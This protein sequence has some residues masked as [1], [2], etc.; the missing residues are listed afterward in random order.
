VPGG[1]A[2]LR[3]LLAGVPLPAKANLRTR[4]A[5]DPDRAAPYV[6]VANPLADL[7]AGL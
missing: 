5:R 3:A 1:A 7:A 6:A 4:W 2:R